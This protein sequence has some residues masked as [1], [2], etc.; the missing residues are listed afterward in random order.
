MG[1]EGIPL[2]EKW[3]TTGKLDCT[4]ADETPPTEGGRRDYYQEDTSSRHT[5]IFE[6]KNS[7]P[8]VTNFSQL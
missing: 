2:I 4:N 7:N 3:E 8:K 6:K 1:D 5:G